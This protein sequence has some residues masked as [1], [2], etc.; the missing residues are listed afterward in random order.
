M[1][2]ALSAEE[3]AEVVEDVRYGDMPCLAG[4]GEE[5]KHFHAAMA[6]YGQEYGFTREDVYLCAGMLHQPSDPE[7]WIKLG[8][9]ADRIEALLPPEDK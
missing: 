4:V 8:A 2:P 3:W 1:K 9:L 6:L 7:L 5:D